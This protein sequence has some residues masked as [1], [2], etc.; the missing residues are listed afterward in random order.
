MVTSFQIGEER[1]LHYYF[2]MNKIITRKGEGLVI[3]TAHQSWRAPI[4]IKVV[5]ETRTSL[6]TIFPKQATWLG[7]NVSKGLFLFWVF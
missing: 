5:E 3:H 1:L 6:Q 7:E 4:I 2:A